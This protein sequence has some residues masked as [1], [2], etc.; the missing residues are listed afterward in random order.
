MGSGL[1]HQQYNT[2]FVD[3]EYQET[4]SSD[5]ND[6]GS[7]QDDGLGRVQYEVSVLFRLLCPYNNT[8]MKNLCFRIRTVNFCNHHFVH[9]V[10][11]H[12]FMTVLPYFFFRYLC[13]KICSLNHPWWAVW[14][15]GWRQSESVAVICLN[16]PLK[17]WNAGCTSI[18]TTLTP[19][20]R[21]SLLWVRK[22]VWLFYR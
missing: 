19:A 7:E 2:L 18:A 6:S 12:S 5:E 3:N 15:W 11:C 21:R 16:M 8:C 4:L 22:L 10:S 13:I 1:N 14:E 17:S 20:M 9:L